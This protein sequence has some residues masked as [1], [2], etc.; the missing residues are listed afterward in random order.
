ML[1]PLRDVAPHTDLLLSGFTS[2]SYVQVMCEK[3]GVRQVSVPLQPYRPTRSGAA[4]MLT[5]LPRSE[6]LVNLWIGKM[7]ER[8]MWSVASES[9]NEL[10]S[11]I[12]LPPHTARSYKRLARATPV[13][14]GFSRHVI[15][16]PTDWEAHVQVAGYWFLDHAADYE[17]PASLAEFLAA[18]EPPVYVG[19]GS[20]A[21]RDPDATF[22]LMC[23]ALAG[24]A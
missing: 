18:G 14:Y 21:H 1:A 22:R 23:D 16:P 19:F 7:M 4:T 13:V 17:P 8:M 2:D 12:G 10:R 20:M 5:M 3:Y 15:P 11:A 6:S 24:V 9:T